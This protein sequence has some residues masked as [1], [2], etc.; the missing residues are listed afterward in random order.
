MEIVRWKRFS[1]RGYVARHAIRHICV[2]V[3]SYISHLAHIVIAAA[4][5]QDEKKKLRKCLKKIPPKK[6]ERKDKDRKK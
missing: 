2:C 6:K 5:L 1:G 4:I 3:A